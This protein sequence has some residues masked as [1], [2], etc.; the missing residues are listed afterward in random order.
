MLLYS[1]CLWSASVYSAIYSRA[2]SQHYLLE[3]PLYDYSIVCWYFVQVADT[4]SKLIDDLADC[5]YCN[6]VNG[7][8]KWKCNSIPEHL[9]AKV[10]HESFVCP[11]RG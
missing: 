5:L 10:L 9:Y 2:T 8:F 4:G 3:D 6:N 11:S 1:K 7:L